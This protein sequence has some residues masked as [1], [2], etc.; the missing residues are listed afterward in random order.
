MAMKSLSPVPKLLLSTTPSSVLSSDKNFFFV[1]FVG[2]YCKSKR[3][4]RRLR[5]DSSS[6]TS[7]ASPLSRLSSVRAVIDLER[8]HDKDLASP[9]YLKPQVRSFTEIQ[10]M[11]IRFFENLSFLLLCF[12]LL[13][14]KIYCLR[15]ELVVSGL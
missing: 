11:L 1:D 14:W 9:S 6:S 5:G 7:R 4:R 10:M 13:T 2:L 15:E 8:V 12:R 3:T